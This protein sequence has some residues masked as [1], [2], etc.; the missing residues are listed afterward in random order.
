MKCKN[1]LFIYTFMEKFHTLPSF[2]RL[3]EF[4]TLRVSHAACGRFQWSG[5]NRYPVNRLFFVLETGSAGG[6]TIVN[7]SA[8]GQTLTLS[9]NRFYFMPLDL[10]LKFEFRSGLTIAAFHF[11]LELFSGYDVFTGERRCRGDADDLGLGRLFRRMDRKEG[12]L[13]ATAT[14]KGIAFLAAGRFIRQNRE[15]LERRSRI[16][17]RYENLLLFIRR[18]ADAQT[19]IVDL[20]AVADTPRDALSRS[21]PLD[22]GVTLKTYLDR[23]IVR[24]AMES[25]AS[26]GKRAVDV[27]EELNF[28]NQ[29]YFSRFFKKHTGVTP[30][31]FRATVLG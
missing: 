27:A 12:E 28:N 3:N 22:M 9:K 15:G 29:Y 18:E 17:E 5:R 2:E 10:D 1:T 14:L 8:D 21:F 23:Q 4:L 25:L 16:R 19:T 30:G 11:N 24:K 26:G 31:R 13:E 6:G 20:A 7:H